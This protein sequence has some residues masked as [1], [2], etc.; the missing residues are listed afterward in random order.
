MNLYKRFVLGSP[1]S[2][3][4][5]WFGLSMFVLGI[6]SAIFNIVIGSFIWGFSPFNILAGISN[7]VVCAFLWSVTK[8]NE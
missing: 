2:K 7:V 6:I 5:G 1:T 3:A 4:F 8:P